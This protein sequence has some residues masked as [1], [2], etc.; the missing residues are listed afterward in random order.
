[1][2]RGFTLVE[3]IIAIAIVSVVATIMIVGFSGG[4]SKARDAARKSEIASFGRFLT[5]GC[6][7]PD[8][9]IGDYDLAL[10]VAELRTKYPQYA[11][12]LSR[13]PRDPKGGT[14][15]ETHYRYIVETNGKCA[16]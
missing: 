10:I 7:V 9:G 3:V 13:V 12:Q 16:L 2:R 8:A 5:L 4:R 15:I 14:E 6:Y 1:M 11:Q